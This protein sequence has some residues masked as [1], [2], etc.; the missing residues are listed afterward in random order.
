MSV[1]ASGKTKLMRGAVWTV[2]LRWSIRLLGL[3]N[4][5]VMARILMPSEYGIVAMASVVVGIVQAFLDFGAGTALLRKPSVDRDDIDSAWTLRVLQGFAVCLVLAVIA[6]IASQY[7]SEPR[8][9]VVLWALGGGLVVSSAANVGLVMAQKEFNFA[10]EFKVQIIANVLRV[11]VTVAAG[12][13][14]RDYRALV[15][16]IVVTHVC[17]T[18]LSYVFHAYRPRWNTRKIGELWAVTKWLML[19]GIG[20]FILRRGDELVAGRIVGSSGQFGL[21]SVGSDLGQMPTSEVGPAMLRALLPLLSS[22]KGSAQQINA[23]VVKVAGA[24]NTVTLALGLGLA[25]LAG[26]FTAVVLGPNWIP[27]QAF[28]AGFAVVGVLQSM[29]GA[30]TTLLVMRGHT[31]QHSM[32]VWAEFSAFCLAAVL[33]VPSM[34]LLGLVWARAIGSAVAFAT[35]ALLA[36]RHCELGLRLL[37]LPLMR[38]L[39]GAV[40]MFML[41]HWLSAQV[42]GPALQLLV[43][44]AAG[45]FFYVAWCLFSWRIV[46]RPDGLESMVLAQI[47]QRIGAARQSS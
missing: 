47:T 37:A 44:V 23:A 33:L 19:S 20:S 9:M 13:W 42:D 8:V 1:S 27:A 39:F 5:V 24:A 38:P 15:L 43:G 35:A 10:L 32:T 2:G 29:P 45:A 34:S 26:P 7:F 41:V 28:I 18:V 6:P 17:N 25:A 36:R 22:M 11:A 30:L 3:L 31:K 14:L 46:G 12:L 16:G 4:T 40:L 21:Y